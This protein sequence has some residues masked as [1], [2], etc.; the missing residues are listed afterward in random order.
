MAGTSLL[1][2]VG[3]LA[4]LAVTSFGDSDLSPMVTFACAGALVLSFAY[5]RAS[6][7]RVT[8]LVTKIMS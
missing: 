4:S 8:K 5:Q 3:L 6:R 2:V 1:L 7:A